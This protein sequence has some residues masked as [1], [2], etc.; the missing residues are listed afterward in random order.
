[1]GI[2][3]QDK[4]TGHLVTIGLKQIFPIPEAPKL[5]S[6]LIF[7]WFFLIKKILSFNMCYC[8]LNLPKYGEKRAPSK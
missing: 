5:I 3:N 1:M 8:T 6:T 4:N 2:A 7:G